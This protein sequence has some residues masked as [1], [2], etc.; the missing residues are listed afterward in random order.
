MLYGAHVKNEIRRYVRETT[1]WGPAARLGS[2][3]YIKTSPQRCTVG[4]TRVEK[5]S[6]VQWTMLPFGEGRSGNPEG[7]PMCADRTHSGEAAPRLPASGCGECGS[8]QMQN[9]E[10]NIRVK[11]ALG[12]KATEL[13][14]PAPAPHNRLGFGILL[15]RA[16]Q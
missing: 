14:A 16:S 12:E 5:E 9:A 6:A 3:I 15:P 1:I 7:A 4:A 11:C 2:F 13:S 10:L 8:P